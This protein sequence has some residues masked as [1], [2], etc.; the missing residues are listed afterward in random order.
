MKGKEQALMYIVSVRRRA[1]GRKRQE[2]RGT[3]T[4]ARTRTRTRARTK[5]R[6]RL[7]L[8]EIYSECYCG[9]GAGVGAEIPFLQ[10]GRTFLY[11]EI[12]GSG[13]YLETES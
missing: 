12:K 13:D 2:V 5:T 3:I 9:T 11:T 6:T 10:L 7:T 4:R 8:V 1:L